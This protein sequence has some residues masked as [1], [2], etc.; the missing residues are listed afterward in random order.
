MANSRAPVGK[1]NKVQRKKDQ[2]E[3]VV[4]S[5]TQRRTNSYDY[6]NFSKI[7]PGSNPNSFRIQDS[8]VNI[9]IDESN[10][11]RYQNIVGNYDSQQGFQ[12]S[13]SIIRESGNIKI[14]TQQATKKSK[15]T[16]Q[17]H[18][19]TSPINSKSKPM[20]SKGYSKGLF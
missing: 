13:D 11:S 2:P 7:H 5:Y 20:P 8:G 18:R 10:S 6:T 17:T 14:S 4:P 1:T 19:V 12:I 16:V 9:A 3:A 15:A